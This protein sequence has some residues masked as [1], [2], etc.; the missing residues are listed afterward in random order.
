[1]RKKTLAIVLVLIIAISAYLVYYDLTSYPNLRVF[2]DIEK[3]KVQSAS[4]DSTGVVIT[5]QTMDSTTVTLT[6]ATIKNET[7]F[8]VASIP[9]NITINQ[10]LTSIHVDLK[11]ALPSGHYYVMVVST[12]HSSFISPILTVK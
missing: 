6:S 7:N 10:V 2:G 4:F 11:N 5:V 12:R 9:L 8:E 3:L 1:M